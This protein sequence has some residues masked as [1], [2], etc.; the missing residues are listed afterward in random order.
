MSVP[1]LPHRRDLR[2]GDLVFPDKSSPDEI[3]A[4]FGISK[5]AFKRA[6]GHLMKAGH[7]VHQ[8]DGLLI[9]NDQN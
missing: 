3:K 2:Q 7:F 1:V 8:E 5:G 6:V 9:L 4:Y